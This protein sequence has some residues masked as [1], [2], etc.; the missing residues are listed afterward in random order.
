MSG[1][2]CIANIGPRERA[3]RLR[4]GLLMAAVAAG[5]IGA[6]ALLDLPRAARLLVFFPAWM[7]GLGIFQHMEK[8]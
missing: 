5:W 8:T 1:E 3:K 2:V 6:C 4:L 7:A